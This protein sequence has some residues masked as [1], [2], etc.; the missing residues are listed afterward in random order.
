MGAR[1]ASPSDRPDVGGA[2]RS[3]A[4]LVA[5]EGAAAALAGDASAH[6]TRGAT[7]E[8]LHRCCPRG[9]VDG[10]EQ[11]RAVRSARCGRRRPAPRA[12]RITA[13]IPCGPARRAP[14]HHA[15]GHQLGRADAPHHLAHL[16]AAAAHRER[17]TVGQR[18][19]RAAGADYGPRDQSP[20]DWR[21]R[22]V[23]PR[24]RC[25]A[26]HAIRQ[27]RNSARADA[28]HL[29]LLR[30]W[31]QAARVPRG[32][33]AVHGSGFRLGP[34]PPAHRRAD[35]REI[36]GRSPGDRPRWAFSRAEWRPHP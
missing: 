35:C 18:A 36:A 21:Q 4:V 26:R 20:R 30:A 12:D 32:R 5:P 31:R 16:A 10:P 25:A 7:H 1:G 28:D 13:R 14:A 15:R 23:A 17:A 19:S 22:H 33:G 29:W 3:V 34:P 8:H 2:H 24:R 9:G 6:A 11:S 27:P